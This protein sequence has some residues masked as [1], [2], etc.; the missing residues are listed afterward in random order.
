MCSLC[1]PLQSKHLFYTIFSIC[2]DFLLS[3]LFGCLFRVFCFGNFFFVVEFFNIS[4]NNNRISSNIQIG[5]FFPFLLNEPQNIILSLRSR[6]LSVCYFILC[7]AYI[8]SEIW[9]M[10]NKY[11]FY[12][13]FVN[14]LMINNNNVNNESIQIMSIHEGR[15][16]FTKN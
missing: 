3:S 4:N 2:G 1:W 16:S 11:L 15:F 10:R 5:V 9:Q 7:S 13:Y 12:L 14:K 6:I 8:L